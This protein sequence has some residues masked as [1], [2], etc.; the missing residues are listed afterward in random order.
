MDTII[1]NYNQK[2]KELI[3]KILKKFSITN[4]SEEYFVKQLEYIIEN[5]LS[6]SNTGAF[7]QKHKAELFN[8]VKD[9][10]QTLENQITS[11]KSSVH[12]ERPYVSD[13]NIHY[14]NVV[15]SLMTASS[16]FKNDYRSVIKQMRDPLAQE[17]SREEFYKALEVVG[18]FTEISTS[19]MLKPC[20]KREVYDARKLF[21]ICLF[22]YYDTT[23]V[24]VG[25]YLGKNHATILHYIV[26]KKLRQ[27]D[28]QKKKTRAVQV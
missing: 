4:G 13:F 23:L 26:D 16:K 8:E 15:D 11:L 6:P 17:L 19:A 25:R 20:R 12:N 10:Y 22:C 14:V 27:Y 3:N 2:K 21:V 5:T 1:I 18:R 28:N 7:L 9:A 24:A